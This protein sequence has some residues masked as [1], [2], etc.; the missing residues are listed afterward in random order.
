MF[1]LL[2]II[3]TVKHFYTL[4]TLLTS[5][6]RRDAA[7]HKKLMDTPYLMLRNKVPPRITSE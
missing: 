1:N 4:H 7:P 6:G 2:V 3:K 5:V